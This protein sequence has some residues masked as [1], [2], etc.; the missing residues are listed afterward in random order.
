M[1]L[2]SQKTNFVPF[3]PT[4][5]INMNFLSER[6]H[7]FQVYSQ[8]KALR[9]FATI[10]IV[11]CLHAMSTF[12]KNTVWTG[13]WATAAQSVDAP[14]MPPAPG[15]SNNT[16][17]EIIRVSLGGKTIRL[18]FSNYFSRS[19]IEIKAVG[20]AVAN[21]KNEVDISTN[22]VLKFNGKDSITLAGR[23]EI[24]CDPIQFKIKPGSRLAITICYGNVAKDI[25]GHPASRTTSYLIAG[26]SSTIA[27]F[28]QAVKADR[29]YTLSRVE[30]LAPK[31]ASAIAVLGNSIADGRGSGINQ[32][33][34][35]PDVLSARLLQNKSTKLRGMLNVSIGGSSA[36]GGGMERLEREVFGM[37]NVKYLIVTIGV[38]DIG[39]TRSAERA[40]QVADNLINFYKQV[41]EKCHAKGIKVYGAPILP[42]GKSMYDA[43]YRLLAWAKVNTWIRTGKTFD[44]VIDFE[45]VMRNPEAPT[46]LLPNVHDNDWLHPNQLGYKLMGESVDVNLFK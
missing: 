38:N 26:N 15:L 8:K 40:D 41:V 34:R 5:S 21:D 23:T 20:I 24:T 29:Y 19:P 14:N 16:F 17:R 11:F 44:A 35:W 13:S 1:V 31:K 37:S 9:L 25:T 4:K 22:K 10:L 6:K 27:D 7:H 2:S 45:P 18:R 30:V 39:T 42:F 33:N 12:A 32:Q 28:S 3:K 36:L 46:S 43:D